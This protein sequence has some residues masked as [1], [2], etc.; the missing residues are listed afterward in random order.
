MVGY[1]KQCAIAL[2]LLLALLIFWLKRR[3]KKKQKGADVDPGL[4]VLQVDDVVQRPLPLPAVSPEALGSTGRLPALSAAGDG[5]DGPSDAARQ[6]EEVAALVERQPE[7]V[8]EL[9]RGWLADRRS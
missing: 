3:K 8:A 6:R 7:E 9:L 2:V 5:L 1:A 4:H